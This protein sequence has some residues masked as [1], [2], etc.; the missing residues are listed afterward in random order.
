MINIYIY[1]SNENLPNFSYRFNILAYVHNN[2]DQFNGPTILMPYENSATMKNGTPYTTY[3]S[4]S[5]PQNQ[6]DIKSLD[7][8]PINEFN[9]QHSIIS[10]DVN[11]V[12][13]I[14]F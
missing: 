7:E 2:F 9:K 14:F 3:T 5:S 6:T 12:I 11:K 1:P 8:E 4:S 13:T 10:E